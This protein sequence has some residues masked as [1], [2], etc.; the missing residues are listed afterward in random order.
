MDESTRKAIQ[1]H[2]EAIARC[3]AERGFRY[4]PEV[5]D[6]DQASSA[7]E[8][9]YSYVDPS[10]QRVSEEFFARTYGLGITDGIDGMRQVEPNARPLSKN[11]T[12][13][14]GLSSEDGTRYS[15][16]LRECLQH[17]KPSM[18]E[19]E[20]QRF[21]DAEEAAFAHPEMI[22]ALARWRGCMAERGFD[23]D[24]PDEA[25][26]ALRDEFNQLTM[27]AIANDQ[28]LSAEQLQEFRESEVR[29]AVANLEC[30]GGEGDHALGAIFE[31]LCAELRSR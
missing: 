28:P 8:A 22:S 17:V 30:G 31:R 26:E 15:Q 27:A 7:D 29:F 10:G 19:E 18:S 12:Y 1:D 6:L 21:D 5:P 11:D 16:R 2:E 4:Y 25:S 3:M 13:V 24:D 20:I 14:N 9:E 23:Y